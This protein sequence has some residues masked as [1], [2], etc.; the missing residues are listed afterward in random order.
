M[1]PKSIHSSW[2]LACARVALSGL[3]FGC[4]ND[5]PLG[6]QDRDSGLAGAGGGVGSGGSGSGGSRADVAPGTGGAIGG[7]GGAQSPDAPLGT[8]GLI[9][10]TG[11][12]VGTGGALGSGGRTGTGGVTS[13]GGASGTGGATGAGGGTAARCGTIAGLV[14]PSGQFCDLASNCGL[15]SDAAGT[16]KLTGA[17][18]GCTA[19]W[20]PVCGCDHKTY[21]N[22]CVR[23]AAG[24]LKAADGACAG[25]TGGVSGAGGATGAGGKTGAGGAV[26]TG[27][28]T[29]AGGSTNKTC[30]GTAAVTCPAGQYC[31]LAS[32]C[33]QAANASGT[34]RL[35]GP[36]VGCTADWVPVCGCDGKTYSN[37]CVRNAAGVLKASDGACSGR[38]GG[39]TTYPSAY[40][41]W[42]AP[43]GVV[44]T[45]PAVVVS[46]AGWAD[47]WNS[48]TQFPPE[49]P[50]A[51][52]TGTYALTSAQTDDL[53]ARVA[54]V[55]LAALPHPGSWAE[56]YPTLYYRACTGCTVVTLTYNLAAQLAPEMDPV[57][58]WFDQV[59]GGTTSANP[60]NYCSF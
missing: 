18:V 43:G 14:C 4:G 11:G 7:T 39:V 13:A 1:K 54:S 3:M 38:D 41:A 16:C 35:T 22:D 58:L 24:V 46:G 12:Q 47:T 36:S 6:A 49:T 25:G 20:V 57:W 44:G 5:V 52:P 55:N 40:L 56:C 29:G 30:G 50:P 26:G 28:A 27:G 2:F 53:F 10:P 17:S 45:G 32:S 34:C 42:Q 21:S 31:D 60:R 51:S 59:L 33:G 8:G 48:V 37:D 19:D 15:I 23:V 9:G